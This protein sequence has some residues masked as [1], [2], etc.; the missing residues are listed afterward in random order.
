MGARLRLLFWMA[1]LGF[2][3]LAAVRSLRGAAE[4]ALPSAVVLLTAVLV[5]A[6]ALLV[7]ARAWTALLEGTAPRRELRDGFI[8]AQVGKYIPGGVWLGAGQLG[9]AVGA[10]VPAARAVGAMAVYAV[11]LLAAAGCLVALLGVV[12]PV[13]PE[14]LVRLAPAGLIP[15]LLLDRRWMHGAVGRVGRRFPAARGALLAGQ[16]EIA[17][18]FASVVAALL[19]A[20]AAFALLLGAL[21]SPAPPLLAGSAFLVA[22]TAGFLV[23]GLPSGIGVREAVL[24]ALLPGPAGMVL[25]ASLAQR[26]TQMAAEAL[27]LLLAR[28]QP[29][30][31]TDDPLL[32]RKS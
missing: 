6:G 18:A 10:G 21:G 1:G 28:V 22:W 16:G 29:R 2:L 32:R 13:G 14:W 5:A 4:V 11:C 27:L 19:L 9:F 30:A 20:G 12:A 26:L 3:A 8:A 31:A 7:A 17:R 23:P 25:A 24:V 15:A